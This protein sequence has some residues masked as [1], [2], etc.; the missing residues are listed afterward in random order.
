MNS[1]TPDVGRWRTNGFTQNTITEIKKNET[2]TG[3]SQ[4]K[5][6]ICPEKNVY[7]SFASTKCKNCA[8]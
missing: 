6:K 7:C 2:E 4:R 3:Y 8:S 1:T 5:I